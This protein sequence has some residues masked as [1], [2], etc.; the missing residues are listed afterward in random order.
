LFKIRDKS[1][2]IIFKIQIKRL[3]FRFVRKYLYCGRVK[4]GAFQIVAPV[5]TSEAKQSKMIIINGLLRANRPRNDDSDTFETT[6]F[7]SVGW[8]HLPLSE[9]DRKILMS[10]VIL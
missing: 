3:K 10:L 2:E 1:K 6:L 8:R 7:S 5:I 9:A 4:T